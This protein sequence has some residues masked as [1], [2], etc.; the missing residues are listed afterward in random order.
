MKQET[1]RKREKKKRFGGFFKGVLIA[2][3][4]LCAL[5]LLSCAAVYAYLSFTVDTRADHER[6]ALARAS[7]VTRL[8]YDSTE[9]D[10]V[11]LP[12]E[13]EEER[14]VGIE[15]R[16]WTP[17]EEMP[18]ALW[19]AFVA[20]EDK[21]FFEHDGVDILR[22][23]KAIVNYFLGFDRRFGGSTITQ[24]LVKNIIG[25]KEQTPMRKMREIYRALKLER[26][27]DK[28][29]ILELYLNVVPLGHNL[30]GVGA[31]AERYFGKS[32]SELSTAECAALAALTNSPV[33]YDLHKKA[34]D[35][36]ARR[37]LVLS[38]MEE[39]GYLSSE[40]RQTAEMQSVTPIPWENR[41]EKVNSWYTEQV[42]A[43]VIDALV[44]EK[45]MS[46]TQAAR[47]VYN[48]GLKI[49]TCAVP[50][51]QE[52][53]ESYFEREGGFRADL[54]YVMTVLSSKT[55][56]LLGIVGREGEKKGNRLLNYATVKRPPGS[57]IKPLSVYAPALQE[58]L[59]NYASVID[60]VPVSFSQT[61]NGL[62]P[63]PYN[64]PRVYSGLTDMRDAIAYSKNTVAVKLYEK[65]GRELSYHYL[66]SKMHVDGIVRE[67][68]NEQGQTVTD[69]AA[70]P[71]ALGQLTYGASLLD[72][73]AAYGVFSGGNYRAPISY[74]EVYDGFGRLLLKNE[75]PA[76]KVLSPQ[77]AAIMTKLL[78]SVTEYGTASSLTLTDRMEVAGKTGTS[79]FDR[80]R[81]FIGYTPEYIGGILCF[82]EEEQEIG[83]A[84]PSHLQ[85]WDE[86]MKLIHTD[87]AQKI[88]TEPMGIYRCMYCRDSG[89][90]PCQACRLDAR[91]GRVA[92]GYF[93][94]EN[95]PRSVCDRH[96]EFMYDDE[97]EGIVLD[98]Q[99]FGYGRRV[100][101]VR[102]EE[103]DFPMQLI[104]TDAQYI[105]RD[106]HGASPSECENG[107]YFESILPEGHYVGISVVKGRQFNA[108]AHKN[109]DWFE[110]L[111]PHFKFRFFGKKNKKTAS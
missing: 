109:D 20:I 54:R 55:G 101:L 12:C 5:F 93:T 71:L 103:R 16:I 52:A 29:Q 7:C 28:R 53:L 91:G 63:W 65:L 60:D 9:N 56:Q 67:A 104:V 39:K 40:E 111:L 110:D 61:A 80:D 51:I 33:R 94:A 30:I 88:F 106:L 83:Y 23:G 100:S 46:R 84:S 41:A 10:D 75:Q 37:E 85:A 32:V 86:V 78:G 13:W 48:G 58:G 45:K 50:R 89:G 81:W 105:W 76:E 25:D 19:Q 49:Y 57:V 90:Y 27:C 68:K 2:F 95:L 14:L 64:Y 47:T 38:A 21:R 17:I 98:G 66:A 108:L 74:T 24:Q 42:I 44:R 77:N 70:A 72:L 1:K 79:S 22:T 34:V 69:L 36:R 31:A 102:E 99:P 73:C 26:V 6:V 82:S 4:S 35:N 59:I 8:Y 92:V 97:S 15:E 107:A 96:R 18:D 3:F 11:Y 43:D 62:R 87:S